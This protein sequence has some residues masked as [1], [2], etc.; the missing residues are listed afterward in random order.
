ML[1]FDPTE[2]ITVDQ[3]LKH[4]Y[5][6][7]YHDPNDEPS[8]EHLFAFQLEHIDTISELKNQII[9]EI[10]SYHPDMETSLYQDPLL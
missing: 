5:L 1:Q 8:H 9:Q 2:R 3:A 4:S 10:A 7:L 6:S